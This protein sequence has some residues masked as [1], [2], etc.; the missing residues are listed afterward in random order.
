MGRG[1]SREGG[2]G[3]GRRAR[4][5]RPSARAGPALPRCSAGGGRARD[6]QTAPHRLCP[7]PPRPAPTSAAR[8][9]GLRSQN[10]MGAG[11]GG[12]GARGP[13]AGV[14]WGRARR[15]AAGARRGRRRRPRGAAAPCR[16]RARA[17]P[18]PRPRAP[19]AAARAHTH[20]LG[21]G[22]RRAGGWS[23]SAEGGARGRGGAGA[24]HRRRTPWACSGAQG[25][26]SEALGAIAPPG[27]AGSAAGRRS[28]TLSSITRKAR[29]GRDPCRA[30]PRR[31]RGHRCAARR[32]RGEGAGG[33]GGATARARRDRGAGWGLCS[34]PPP[35]TKWTR[36]FPHPVLI[37]HAAS[38]TPY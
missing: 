34:A 38:L 3:P 22:H 31:A 21:G 16:A 20:A 4:G 25:S 29:E 32:A 11:R 18:Q 2:G 28:A 10:S 1:N 8:P 5:L 26:P 7:A 27:A 30:A 17:R 6:P 15:R 36:R 37:G 13:G 35:R 23:N 19:H 12:G 14:H 9:G 33:R 24:T